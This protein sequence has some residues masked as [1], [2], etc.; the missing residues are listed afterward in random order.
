MP[1][2]SAQSICVSFT[3]AVK[4]CTMQP[5]PRAVA[6]NRLLVLRRAWSKVGQNGTL[7]T[8]NEMITTKALELTIQYRLYYDANFALYLCPARLHESMCHTLRPHCLELDAKLIR[9]AV[10]HL[11]HL[12]IPI[13]HPTGPFE[14]VLICLITS[15]FLPL[16][17]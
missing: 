9:D 14:D 17:G 5:Q 10:D 3:N 4:L 15:L 8:L 16:R 11:V 1:R 7:E 6:A 13:S 12:P 2:R